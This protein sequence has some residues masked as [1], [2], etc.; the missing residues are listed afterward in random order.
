MGATRKIAEL[1]LANKGI[2]PKITEQYDEE[3]PLN[4][5][6]YQYPEEGAIITSDTVVEL[7]ISLGPE[8]EDIFMPTLLGKTLE[9]ARPIIEEYKLNVIETKYETQY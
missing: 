1:T 8:P 5:V 6:I 7:V 2:T 9:E 4:E 3:A